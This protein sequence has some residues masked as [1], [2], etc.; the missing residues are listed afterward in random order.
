MNAPATEQA[1][2]LAACRAQFVAALT[3]A[4]K[5]AN[6]GSPP[7]LAALSRGAEE[8]FDELA[9]LH[10]KEE[11][12][13]LRGV[14]ASR[15]SLVHPEDMDLTVELINLAHDLT[16][17]CE[18]ELPRLQQLFMRLLAQSSAV[19]DQLPVGPDAVC[20]ALRALCD[21][22]ELVGEAR[23][24]VPKRIEPVLAEN[25]RQ[26]YLQLTSDLR[27][28]GLAPQPLTPTASD[29][30]AAAP[31][32]R[33]SQGYGGAEQVALHAARELDGPPLGRLQESLRRDRAQAGSSSVGSSGAP[34]DPGLLAA[35]LERVF[36]W[37]NERQQE[38]AALS[39]GDPVL[40]PELGELG[41]LLPAT[42]GAALDAVDLSFDA[43]LDDPALAAA[44]RPSLERL[45]LPL[46]KLALLDAAALS[47]ANHPARKFLDTLLSL[48]LSLVPECTAQHP[49]CQAIEAA[50][51]RV[52]QDFARDP[53]VFAQATEVLATL[54]AE[55]L[56]RLETRCAALLPRAEAEVR[57][58][59][60]RSRA[61]RAIRALCAGEIPA[62]V[63]T[64]LEQLWVRVL[65]AV[66]QQNGEKSEAWF[67]ALSIA[68]QL[69]DSVQPK[70]DATARQRLSSGL[71]ELIASLR[72]GLD[73]IGAPAQLREH[74]FQSF[75]ACH[76]AAMRGKTLP[77]AHPVRLEVANAPR[78]EAQADQPG[79]SVVRL[80]PDLSGDGPAPEWIS[81]LEVGA[82][83]QL[84][85]PGRA[86]QRLRIQWCSAAPRLL[87]AAAP[88]DGEVLLFPQRWL[89][90]AAET[91][92]A[93]PVA[94]DGAFERAAERVAARYH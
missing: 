21:E 56:A 64:F 13:R 28:A 65:A 37:L 15:I 35:I 7:L 62:P 46:S 41:Q 50:T 63:R 22:G 4:A 67:R 3:D 60:S 53:A 81:R 17:A 85:L 6:L 51:R 79:F 9:G 71:P 86:A 78:I 16:D 90:E 80:P 27:D 76:A 70:L 89:E 19:V 84:T 24:S 91:L 83:L 45:R 74:A 14:T 36:L 25:L 1:K 59:H 94:T 92:A 40:K 77:P 2:L 73:F 55:R 33:P 38:A 69:V 52:Q 58:E 34:L 87:L 8:A 75:V 11:F 48:A 30:R 43:V 47:D 26:L 93:T 31:E 39:Y 44:L 42:N 72:A 5:L 20:V 23:L 57:R 10:S 88:D 82:W 61:G 18:R 32:G 29:T 54:A 12:H 68:N 66:H 49:V